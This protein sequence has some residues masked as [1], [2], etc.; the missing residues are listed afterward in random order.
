VHQFANW[1][2]GGFVQFVHRR[3][4]PADSSVLCN[5]GCMGRRGSGC[6]GQGMWP[7]M[8]SSCR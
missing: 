6:M 8:S 4:Q 2:A 3:L 5:T 1:H 7:C